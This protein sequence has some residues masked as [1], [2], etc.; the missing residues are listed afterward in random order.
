MLSWIGLAATAVASLTGLLAL[1]IRVRW[2]VRQEKARGDSLIAIAEA[3]PSGGR[4]RDQ[5]ADGSCITLTVPATPV[6]GSPRG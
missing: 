3:L 1:W 2:R 6:S 5:R 4:L